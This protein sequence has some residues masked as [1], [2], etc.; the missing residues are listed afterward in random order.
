MFSFV[1]FGGI[2]R[3][4]EIPKG[5]SGISCG[6]VHYSAREPRNADERHAVK[7]V[8]LAKKKASRRANNGKR[9]DSDTVS[10]MAGKII[11]RAQDCGTVA[12]EDFRQAGIPED[13]IDLHR[14]AAFAMARRREPKLDAMGALQ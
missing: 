13:M 4:L 3:A 2:V 6:G 1:I 9:T 10:L 14:D 8:Q 7:V 12:R 5:Q 11:Q